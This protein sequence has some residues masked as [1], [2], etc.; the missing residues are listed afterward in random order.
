MSNMNDDTAR[1]ASLAAQLREV[2]GPDSVSTD[3]GECAALSA[4]VYSAGVTAGMVVTPANREGV[5]KAVAS[6]TAAGF[7]VIARGGGMTYTGGYTPVRADTVMLDTRRL[8]RIVEVS[9]DDMYVTA[10]AGVTW[11]Q[12]YEALE[13]LGLRLPCFG[14]FSGARATVGGGIA[15]GALFFGTARYGTVADA[16]LGLEVVLADGSIVATGQGAVANARK[17]AYRGFGPDFTGAFVHESGALG[18]K[19]QATFRLIRSP[20]HTGYASFAFTDQAHAAA[21]LSEVARAELAEDAYCFDPESTRKNLAGVD[22]AKALRTLAGVMKQEGG[23]FAGLKAG[24]KLATAGRKV[25]PEDAWSM[26][27]ALAGRSAQAVEADVAA[28]RRIA[29][30]C[31]GVELPDSIPRA[32]RGSLFPVLNDVLDPDGA[33]W[34]ALN[35]KVPHSVAPAFIA[36]AEGVLAGYEKQMATHGIRISRLMIAMSTHAFSYEPVLHW[37]DEWLPVHR[38]TPE[39]GH[40]AKL[41]EPAANPAARALVHE[42][43]GRMVELFADWGAASN[44][45]GKTYPYAQLLKPESAALLGRFKASV[46]PKGS[47]NPGTLGLG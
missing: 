14:T 15:N 22:L 46:D 23:L 42:I 13:P 30:A 43:R 31:G 34:A 40:L 28:C 1:I 37:R 24:V 36:A 2:L 25:V 32:V 47:L 6:A 26:H 8:N 10:E 39:P 12:L 11:K 5:A 21:A 45:I 44:Q 33:R 18:V 3:P 27:L 19:V 41:S 17:A 4:D 29:A 9:A 38:N 16:L 7:A 20:A 35:A